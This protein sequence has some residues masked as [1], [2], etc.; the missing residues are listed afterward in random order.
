M[1]YN[2]S[3]AFS[4]IRLFMD[5]LLWFAGMGEWHAEK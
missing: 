1:K 3:F 2:P 4:D 5:H